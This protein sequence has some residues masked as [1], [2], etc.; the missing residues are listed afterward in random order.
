MSSAK[1]LKSFVETL[2]QLFD[3]CDTE[4]PLATCLEGW[5][6][7]KPSKKAF[8]VVAMLDRIC[9]FTLLNIRGHMIGDASFCQKST[10]IQMSSPLPS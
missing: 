10:D 6:L 2:W 1:R 5:R 4:D 8:L 3:G 7:V 9:M